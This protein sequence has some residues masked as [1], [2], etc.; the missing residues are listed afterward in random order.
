MTARTHSPA[1]WL[2]RLGTLAALGA[3]LLLAGCERPPVNTSQQG[4]RGTAM[5]HT[6]NPRLAAKEDA[7]RAV[8]PEDAPPASADGPKAG[9]VYQ[10]VKVL[11]DLS[12]A[13]FNRHMNA[14]T[15]WVSPEQGC[16]YCHV[17]A[18]FADDS[19]YSKVVA[20]RMIQ[21]TQA[22]N[23][24]W[25]VHTGATGVTCYTCH[26]GAPV[27]ANMWFKPLTPVRN[28]SYGG[29]LG[30][31]FGQ[32]K[33]T[34]PG[35]TSLPYDPF[36]GYLLGED[37]IKVYGKQPLPQGIG[38]GAPIQQAEKTYALMM[39]FSKSLGQNCTF[40]H[41]SQNFGGWVPKKVTAWHGI[42]MERD[43]NNTYVVPLTDTL[44]KD[45]LGPHGDIGKAYCATCH[46]GQNKPLGGKE[47]AKLYP[48]LQVLAPLVTLPPPVAEG[49][50]SVLFFGVGSHDLLADQ[51]KGLESLLTALGG[52][53]R[54][55]VLVSGYHSAAGEKAT[56]QE[57]AKKRAQAV[58]DALLAAGVAPARVRLDKP[59]QT[60]ANVA[61]EDPA[62]RRVEVRLQ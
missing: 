62:A 25:K 9:Q 40:C 58:R 32:N 56:N 8:P 29:A 4:F 37:E 2:A 39:H 24:Q 54:S 15:Q 51:T 20:R 36:S 59:Q 45:R 50:R 3:A 19:K 5:Q 17:G 28:A 10:N 48:G 1:P 52:N 23:S 41:N 60:E 53:P 43:I 57:L 26:R 12:V 38:N 18:N 11:G 34:G 49:G 42:R 35:L 27:P 33:A 46:Q 31:D 30:N 6:V 16:N 47:M 22:L 61:G 14:I 55:V 21:M 7:A 13:E 44:P